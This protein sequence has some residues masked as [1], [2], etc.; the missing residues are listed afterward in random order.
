MLIMLLMT[1]MLL[2]SC[3]STNERTNQGLQSTDSLPLDQTIHMDMIPELTKEQQSALDALNT[4]QVS[5]DEMNRL[6]ST[7]AGIDQPCYPPDTSLTISRSELL[8]AMKQ[9]VT[10]NCKNLTIEER[11]ELAT[12][13]VLAQNEYTVSL[14]LDNSGPITYENGTPMKGTWVLPNVL[15]RR[16]VIIQW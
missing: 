6:Y 11:D 2:I 12:Q 9:F 3:T 1:C 8:I 10:I 15:G 14:C 16:D 7:F 13:S 4:L 5:T